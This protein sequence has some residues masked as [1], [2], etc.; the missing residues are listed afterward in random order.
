MSG[1]SQFKN[2]MYRKGAQDAKKARVFAKIAR[3]IY[4]SVKSAGTDPDSNSR[5]RAALLNARAENMPKDNVDRAIKKATSNDAGAD[6]VATR[7]EGYGIGAVAVIVD[8]LTDNKNRT[9]AD[10]RS[11]FSKNGGSL[12][13]SNSVAFQFDKVFCIEYAN[14]V[15]KED[16][17]FEIAIESGGDDISTYSDSFEIICSV[18]NAFEVRENLAKHFGPPKNAKI[19]WKPQNMIDVSAENAKTLLKMIDA[20][21]D[22]DDVQVVTT[23]MNL[24]DEVIAQIDE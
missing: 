11:L 24:T 22:L 17:I 18:E 21:E 2:I 1:H 7:Y 12:G 3:E 6:Y 13:E 5:L 14:N 4:V 10:V 20:L 16:E 23:N 9:A 15:A 19:I 8:A